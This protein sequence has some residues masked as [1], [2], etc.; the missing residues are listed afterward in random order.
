MIDTSKIN[1]PRVAFYFLII[2]LFILGIIF[3]QSIFAYVLSSLFFAYLLNPIV[4]SLEKAHVPRIIGIGIVYFFIIGIIIGIALFVI[5][6]LIKQANE[7]VN[8]ISVYVKNIDSIQQKIPYIDK[9]TDFFNSLQAKFPFLTF[10][11]DLA[12]FG[13]KILD[14]VHNLPSI[15]F[16]FVKNLVSIVALLVTIPIV[17][18]FILNDKEKFMKAFFAFVPN[19]YFE[20]TVLLMRKLDDVAGTYLRALMIEISIVSVL[21]SIALVIVGVPY[22]LLIGIIAGFANAIPYFGPSIGVILAI[23]SV[24]INS[25]PMSIAVYAIIGLYLVQAIDNNIVYP[26]VIGKNT[27]MHPLIIML[28]VIAGG[29]AWGVLGM[30]LSVPIVFLVK[31]IMIVLYKNLKDFEII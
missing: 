17:G 7:L 6:P 20:L 2:S 9:V 29:Y 18:F 5:P 24:I 13:S 22:A 31:E 1:Y 14:Q 19:K 25:Q 21:S 15:L 23:V 10:Q 11:K 8:T 30:F 12:N 4:F 16:D 28:T 3:Y 26:I 27:E